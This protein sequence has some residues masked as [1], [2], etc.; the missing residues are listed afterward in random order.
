M[1]K[2]GLK[3]KSKTSVPDEGQGEA[4]AIERLLEL[5]RNQGYVTYDDVMEAVPEA[6]LN[7]EQLEDALATLIET[8]IEI[9]DTELEEPIVEK[10]AKKGLSRNAFP[11]PATTIAIW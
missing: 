11:P 3:G 8:G 9:S 6:E 5:G 1:T 10:K 7:I 2:E 4:T